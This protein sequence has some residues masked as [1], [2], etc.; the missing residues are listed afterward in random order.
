MQNRVAINGV[1]ITPG[2][3]VFSTKEEIGAYLSNEKQHYEKFKHEPKLLLL[4]SSDS[5]KSTLLKQLKILHGNGFS[6]KEKE[7]AKRR[8]L[9]GYFTGISRLL[10]L[11]QDYE[12]RE[13]VQVGYIS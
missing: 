8:I 11:L 6:D 5:G 1:P 13:V 2:T 7:L 10:S 12:A 4:G 9:Q 3:V